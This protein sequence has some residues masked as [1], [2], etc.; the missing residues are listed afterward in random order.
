MKRKMETYEGRLYV[1]FGERAN[2]AFHAPHTGGEMRHFMG[3]EQSEAAFWGRVPK[4]HRKA[5]ARMRAGRS[6]SRPL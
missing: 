6:V 2:S 3:H 5:W 4:A 1:Q